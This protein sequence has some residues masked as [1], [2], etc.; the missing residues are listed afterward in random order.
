MR[1]P[2]YD[3]H[4]FYSHISTASL[5][6]RFFFWYKTFFFWFSFSVLDLIQYL[7]VLRTQ[8]KW[9]NLFGVLGGKDEGTKVDI[10]N[11]KTKEPY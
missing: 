10:S 3:P 4:S 6:T 8:N 1:S 9:L 11:P 2:L 5:L 7:Q